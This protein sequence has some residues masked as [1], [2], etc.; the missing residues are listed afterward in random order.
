MSARDGAP[1]SERGGDSIVAP[2]GRNPL[3]FS[4]HAARRVEDR[5]ISPL[6]VELLIRYG[7]V[8]RRHGAWRHAFDKASRRRLK[9][10]IGKPAYMRLEDLLDA[11]V[12]VS[13]DKEIIT[14]A[15]RLDGRRKRCVREGARL[16]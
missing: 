13:D 11:Y 9:A 16:H 7:H 8:T 2:F 5:G 14:A 10:A 6:V 3:R 15:W 4:R 12:L 1:E